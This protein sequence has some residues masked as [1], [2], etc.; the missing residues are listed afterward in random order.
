MLEESDLNQILTWLDDV[1]QLHYDMQSEKNELQIELSHELYLILQRLFSGSD[2]VP[3]SSVNMEN[4]D[5]LFTQI[6]NALTGGDG[7]EAFR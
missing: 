2:L 3:V 6:S 1:D 5:L 7:F 4:L